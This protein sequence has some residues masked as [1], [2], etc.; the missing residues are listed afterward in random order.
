MSTTFKF[1]P[2]VHAIGFQ[3]GQAVHGFLTTQQDFNE[4]WTGFQETLPSWSAICNFP[5]LYSTWWWDLLMKDPVHVLVETTLLI[6]VI[7]MF[8]SRSKDWSESKNDQLTRKEEEDL[9]N[10]W[11]ENSRAPLVAPGLPTGAKDVPTFLVHQVQGTKMQVSMDN[12]PTKIYNV[13]N[14]GTFDF[15]GMSAAFT[16]PESSIK[17]A[18]GNELA[19]MQEKAAEDAYNN[20]N[21]NFG[22]AEEKKE[23]EEANTTEQADNDNSNKTSKNGKRKKKKNKKNTASKAKDDDDRLTSSNP[24]K[25]A[26][27]EALQRYG[28]G[29]CGPRGFYGTIDPHLKL[30]EEITKFMGA[31][32]AI[33]YSDG[34]ST[35]S[36]TVAAFCKRGDLLVVD[37]GVR[38]P[39][40]AG[41][42]LSRAYV[43]WFKHNDMEDLSRVVE[44]VAENDKKLGRG[45]NAQRRF[46]I[47]EGLYKNTGQIA[48]LDKI[49]ALKH[50]Y[51]YRLILDESFSFGTLGATG[52]GA[53]ELFNKKLMHDAEVVTIALE[54]AIGSIG[55]VTIGNE[56][57]VD[58]QRLSGSGYCFSAASPPFTASA[59]VVALNELKTRPKELLTK[60]NDNTQYIYDK[61]RIFCEQ[62]E[63]LILIASD[64]RSP[65]VFLVLAECA[66]TEDIDETV[67]LSEVV[68]ECLRR[69]AGMVSAGHHNTRAGVQLLRAEP[70][71]SIRL[72]VS[73]AHTKNDMDFAIE[74]LSGAVDSVLHRY[75]EGEI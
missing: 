53:L 73:A 21:N 1:L 70:Q 74:V 33:L 31:E 20:S 5:M 54:N 42:K 24:V 39:L 65:I 14:F 68:R 71:P 3:V 26:S 12:D 45:P 29:A 66:E 61:L 10:E 57:I 15:L 32:G 23:E 67:F 41:V 22:G 27:V 30:E 9:I 34:A 44:S 46:I 64:M 4:L 2:R 7:Y 55:G 25:Q 17:D 6:S 62:K 51:H 69:G 8:L 18:N 56:E 47:C 75:V 72:C 59:A 43:K 60:L 58:H 37:E 49:V 16:A 52:R 19:I 13:I 48:A 63:D 28:V 50:K 35:V 38:E 40:I 36:S 11:K